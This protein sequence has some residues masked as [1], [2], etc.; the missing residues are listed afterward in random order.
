MRF[1]N[2]TR[3]SGIFVAE[4]QLLVE[5]LLQSDYRVR[6]VLVEHRS[7]D[8][9]S[10]LAD[11]S[12]EILLVSHDQV[13]QLVGYN[14]HRGVLAC[15]ERKP[16][17]SV[18][19]HFAAGLESTAASDSETFVGLVGV[20]DPENVGGI[21]RSCSALGVRRVLIGPGTADPLSRRALRVAMGNT[22]RVDLYRSVEIIADIEFLRSSAK[23]QCMATALDS[24]SLP[25]EACRRNGPVLLL[26]GNER[27][28]LPPEVVASC[29]D[30]VR[31][32][33]EL[34]TDSLNVCVAAG[35]V[36]HYFCRLAG[37]VIERP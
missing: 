17:K 19:E 34:G 12:T 16:E 33:M 24:D 28:G 35:I 27:H 23:V 7:L 1:R 2:W 4:G 32:D 26:M 25:L 21:I 20:Q 10:K 31:I 14:F 11:D 37:P 18:V 30:S 8:R 6:S 22:L 9:I 29:D 5:L 36:L 15:G 3:H 13:E